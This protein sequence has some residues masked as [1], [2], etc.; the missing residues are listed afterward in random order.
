MRSL[1]SLGLSSEQSIELLTHK[2][3][4][5]AQSDTGVLDGLFDASDRPEGGGVIR[6]LNDL[7]EDDRY[8]IMSYCFIQVGP[9]AHSYEDTRGGAVV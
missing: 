8:V 5:R 2:A 7:E 6:W 9:I 4:A 1:M 3:I